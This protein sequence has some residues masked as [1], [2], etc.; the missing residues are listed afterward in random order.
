MDLVDRDRPLGAPAAARRGAPASHRRPRSRCARARTTTE[1]VF[2]G[3]SVSQRVR[4][5]LEQDLVVLGEDLVLVVRARSDAGEEQLPDPGRA[6]RA[7]RVQAAVPGVEVADDADRAGRRAPRPRTPS[8]SIGLPGS[9]SRDVGAEPLVE[10]LVAPLADQVQVELAE[11]RQERVRVV[12]RELA[13]VAVVDLELVAQRQLGALDH[14]L[15]HTG[16]VDLR[17]SRR[18]SLPSIRTLTP[19]VWRRAERAHNDAAVL[20][21]R[22][23]HGVRVRVLAADERRR[24]LRWRRSCVDLPGSSALKQPRDAGD[25]DRNPV[26]AVVELVA[27]LVDRLLELEDREQVGDRRLAARQQ[28]RVDRSRSSGR[29]RSRA[30]A[31]RSPPGARLSAQDLDRPRSRRRTSAAC[32]RRRAAASASGGARTAAG[33]ARPRSR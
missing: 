29:G 7:H 13:G 3:S 1:A 30:P 11:R 15:E 16:G 22:S 8:R 18:G 31:A 23:E 17:A 32:R 26:G 28:R 24:A 14:A 27:E 21:V 2:G 10:L 9:S 20:R 12:D 33:P 19:T 25:R 6:E 4:V 5:G